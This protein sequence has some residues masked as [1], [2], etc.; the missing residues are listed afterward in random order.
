MFI[1]ILIFIMS[2]D[3]LL[4]LFLLH[5][6]PIFTLRYEASSVSY[7]LSKESLLL[8]PHLENRIGND[9]LHRTY[10]GF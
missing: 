2:D 5:F 8:S 9:T 7:P 6:A 1:A 10:E 3:D 4:R